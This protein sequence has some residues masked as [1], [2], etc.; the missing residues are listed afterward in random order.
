MRASRVL[1]GVVGLAAAPRSPLNSFQFLEGCVARSKKLD[2]R[3]SRRHSE[4]VKVIRTPLTATKPPAILGGS[5]M[6]VVVQNRRKPS[7]A[8]QWRAIYSQRPW[9]PNEGSLFSE[10]QV[11]PPV[12]SASVAQP[13][14]PDVRASGRAIRRAASHPLSVTARSSLAARC[15]AI[16]ASVVLGACVASLSVFLTFVLFNFI[17]HWGA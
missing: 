14:H 10:A 17:L 5:K 8:P 4:E 2:Q 1:K 15:M 13:E 6:K 12:T 11:L 9:T 7:P 3:V 16:I